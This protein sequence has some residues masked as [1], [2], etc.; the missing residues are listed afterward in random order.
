[1]SNYRSAGISWLLLVM[2]SLILTGG[3]ISYAGQNIVTSP[4]A[5]GIPNLERFD[6]VF[7]SVTGTPE[8]TSHRKFRKTSKKLSDE[9]IKK[10]KKA[11]IF[12]SIS[13]KEPAQMSATDL[14]I[15]LLINDFKY[16]SKGGRV[17][18]GMFAGKA[19][20]GIRVSLTAAESGEK[21]AD[22]SLSADSRYK[23]GM[24]GDSTPRQIRKM[25]DHI[26]EAFILQKG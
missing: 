20:L 8:V 17:M 5:L 24:F 19:R 13:S 21:L 22:F 9:L 1:M 3:G 2:F 7:I 6:N 26:V 15:T 23:V 18:G 14:K 25:T 11:R 4:T 12:S 10:L 16:T